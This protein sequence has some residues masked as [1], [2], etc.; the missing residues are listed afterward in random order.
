MLIFLHVERVD[1]ET[2][3]QYDVCVNR[4]PVLKS[5]GEDR[6]VHFIMISVD[7]EAADYYPAKVFG[8]HIRSINNHIRLGTDSRQNLAFFLNA[9][10][11]PVAV[12]QRMCLS[13]FHVP[14]D[15]RFV[16]RFHK[17]HFM[18]YFSLFQFI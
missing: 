11:N 16:G 1:K 8:L 6:D 17:Y 12:R 7:A 2:H 18:R 15:Q 4:H 9:I 13:G 14:A 10:L 3:I 5:K